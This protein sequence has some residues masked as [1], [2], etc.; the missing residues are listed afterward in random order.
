[1]QIIK[2]GKEDLKR[3]EKGVEEG[4]ARA[5]AA[6]RAAVACNARNQ[7]SSIFDDNSA[8]SSIYRNP[9]AFYQY[10]PSLHLKLPL[11][12]HHFLNM[13]VKIM[14]TLM[15]CDP[16]VITEHEVSSR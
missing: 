13:S 11:A 4:L 7:S 12:I 8:A 14:P 1:M 10:A 9:R 5:R 3:K 2:G 6:I 16:N 15:F